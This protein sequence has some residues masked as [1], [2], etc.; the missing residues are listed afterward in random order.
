MIWDTSTVKKD[1]LFLTVKL[2]FDEYT[3]LVSYAPQGSVLYPPFGISNLELLER[4]KKRKPDVK[5]PLA[6]W[7][8]WQF[9]P[10]YYMFS[11]R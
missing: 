8:R 4:V 11:G 7:V 5:I 1:Q 9:Q 2:L 6:K 3:A 10:K